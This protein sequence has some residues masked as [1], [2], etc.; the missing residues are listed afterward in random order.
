M[1]KRQF[2]ATAAILLFFGLGAALDFGIS[3]D[4]HLENYKR[5]IERSLHKME[6]EVQ[7]IL[8]DTSF[9]A[10]ILDGV[11]KLPSPKQQADLK[12]LLDLAGKP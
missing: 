4:N 6:G 2:Y 9:L 3:T 8:A 12:Y 1:K 7:T 11:E 10:R 5:R